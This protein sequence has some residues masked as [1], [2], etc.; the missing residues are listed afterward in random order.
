MERAIYL[1]IVES[2]FSSFAFKISFQIIFLCSERQFSIVFTRVSL[3]SFID[4]FWL[5]VPTKPV[6]VDCFYRTPESRTVAIRFG[7]LP[8]SIALLCLAS[9]PKPVDVAPA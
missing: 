8:D 6:A 2:P 3:L 1:V 7:P 9:V 4:M 5:D